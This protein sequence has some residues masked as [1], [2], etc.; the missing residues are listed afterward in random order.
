MGALVPLQ[1]PALIVF[2][3]LLDNTTMLVGEHLK[4]PV[5]PV[6]CV[7]QGNS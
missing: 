2:L 4:E 7:H 3:A 6:Q 5:L 1:E